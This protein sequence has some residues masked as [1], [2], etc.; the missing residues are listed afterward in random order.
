MLRQ[1]LDAAD[2]RQHANPQPYH[3]PSES[4][5][6]LSRQHQSRTQTPDTAASG[7]G[8]ASQTTTPQEGYDELEEGS[9]RIEDYSSS[10]DDEDDEWSNSNSSHQPPPGVA[11]TSWNVM[12]SAF[13]LVANVENLWDS[14]VMN[15]SG[16]TNASNA[17]SSSALYRRRSYLVVFFWFLVLAGSYASERSTFKLLVDQAGPFRLFSVEMVTAVHAMMLGAGM[18]LSNVY[19]NMSGEPENSAS[20]IPLGIPMVDVGCKYL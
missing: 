4:S 11:R 15:E 17:A 13:L 10:D 12:R 3:D 1:A 18:I 7:Y 9:G 19:R 2:G 20:K 5:S 14:P 6:L 16:N 8:T